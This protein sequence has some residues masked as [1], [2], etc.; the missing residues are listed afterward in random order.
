MNEDFNP[1]ELNRRDLDRVKGYKELLDFYHGIHWEGRERRGEKRLTFNY[2]KVFIDKVTSYLMSGVKFAVDSVEDS[3]EARSNA[4]KAEAALYQVYED[5]NLG[6]LDFSP[7]CVTSQGNE[8]SSGQTF[9]LEAYEHTSSG[10]KASLFLY[11]LDGWGQLNTWRARHQFRW[12]KTSSE[13]SVKQI[14]EFVLAR[15]GLKLE[16]KSESSVLTGY[17]PD[18][19]I[20]LNDRSDTIIQRLL[21]FVPDVFFIEGNKAYVVNPQ[22]SD[23]SVYSY[24]GA[25]PVFEG[26]YQ[27][28]AWKLNR[29]QV[30][31]Y[32]TVGEEPII[33]DSFSWD[34]ID[35]VYDRL[36]QL[37]DTNID[38]VARAG[39]RGA[40]Y[41]RETE[42]ESVGGTIRIPVNCGQQLYDVI[43]ITDSR[44]GLDGEKSRVLGLNLTYDTRR[45][46]YE[47]KLSLGKP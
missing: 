5:N 38:T 14:L 32:D 24:G 44:A 29:I 20:H 35:K 1:A 41:L 37:E 7:G 26:K 39:Q 9:T 27:G 3:A 42:I 15:A 30:E 11:A 22:F 21:S 23:S 33:V 36:H 8:V 2:A 17:Y 28:G 47:Q 43:D 10:G 13:L 6:Q 4:Q 45:G 18:F 16:V 40:A 46:E 19:T 31:G 12:N 34:E 25:H